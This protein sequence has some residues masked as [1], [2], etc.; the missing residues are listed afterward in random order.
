MRRINLRQTRPLPLKPHLRT[1]LRLT[2][3]HLQERQ[4]LATLPLPLMRLLLMLQPAMPP[5]LLAIRR[6]PMLPLRLTLPLLPTPP[7][8]KAHRLMQP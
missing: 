4:L 5:L 3:L 7:Q 1:P 6:Q 2:R 8:R